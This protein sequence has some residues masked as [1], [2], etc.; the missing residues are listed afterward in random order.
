MGW[1]DPTDEYMGETFGLVY[2]FMDDIRDGQ[3]LIAELH[4]DDPIIIDQHTK[5]I[6]Y[7]LGNE[8]GGDDPPVIVAVTCYTMSDF[9]D[10]FHVSLIVAFENDEVDTEVDSPDFNSRKN[11][12]WK[13]MFREKLITLFDKLSGHSYI[14]EMRNKFEMATRPVKQRKRGNGWSKV[15]NILDQGLAKQID[16]CR[17]KVHRGNKTAISEWNELVNNAETLIR[18]RAGKKYKDRY[19][20]EHLVPVEAA[21]KWLEFEKNEIDSFKR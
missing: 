12:K 6:H 21:E 2:E 16:V 11:T 20:R 18:E 4:T 7:R 15:R 5:Q 13:E 1:Y 17:M 10:D 19:R 14:K 8:V 9:A 3:L